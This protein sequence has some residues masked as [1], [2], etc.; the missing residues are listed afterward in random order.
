MSALDD[1]GCNT[2]IRDSSVCAGTDDY[3][4]DLDIANFVDGLCI[5]WK[6]WECNGWLQ[7]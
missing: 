1:I 6:M 4:I 2:H 3:L 7:G 5:L